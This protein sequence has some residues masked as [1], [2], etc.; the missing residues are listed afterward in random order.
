[1]AERFFA[2]GLDRAGAP[3]FAHIPRWNAASSLKRLFSRELA[4]ETRGLDPVGRIVSD[5]PAEFAAWD[6]LA[7]AQYLEIKTI[8]SGYILAS[9]GDRMLISHSVE[10]RFPFLDPDVIDFCNGLPPSYKL[11]VLDEK[12]V[13]KRAARDLVPEPILRR[14][15][16]PYRAPD[17]PS[18]AGSGAPGYV[19]ELLG[20]AAVRQAG[21]FEPSGVARL[22]DKCRAKVGQ[23]QF[24]NADNMAFIGVLSSQLLWSQFVRERP[25][26]AELPEERVGTRVT[27]DA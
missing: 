14:P 17:A 7:Q 22:L 12:H 25:R 15:K 19:D 13:L 24:S 8:L 21:L 26:C 10:G 16:Q 27:F 1:M 9:Q 20:D 6:P 11:K 5:L 3:E 18:F 23:G 4:A 2:Q